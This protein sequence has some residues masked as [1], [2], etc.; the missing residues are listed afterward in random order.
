MAS[1]GVV[2]PLAFEQTTSW[3][4]NETYTG[5]CINRLQANGCVM[6]S[7]KPDFCIQ[8]VEWPLDSRPGWFKYVDTICCDV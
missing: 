6:S 1:V 5:W 8:G 4:I 2:R 7:A 3:V